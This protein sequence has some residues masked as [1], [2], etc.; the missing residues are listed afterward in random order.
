M[1]DRDI[2]PFF[3][4]GKKASF[5][6]R[7]GMWGS[8]MFN[9]DNIICG[10][11]LGSHRL[12]AVAGI[13]DKKENFFSLEHVGAK[14]DGIRS[15]LITD[16][17]LATR[18]LRE[19][20]GA[21]EGKLRRRIKS[22]YVNIDS[23]DLILR[24]ANA[25]IPLCERGN[26]IITAADIDLVRSQ[27][28]SLNLKLNEEKIHEFARRY[29]LDDHNKTENPKGLYGHK[30]AIDLYLAAAK[31]SQIENIVKLVNQAGL[32][33]ERVVFSG[34]AASLALLDKGL[35]ES[36]CVLVDIGADLT[37]VLVF[38]GGALC[39][40]EVMRYG[41]NNITASLAEVLK[42]PFGLAE[43]VKDTHGAA[44]SKDIKE[45][46]DVM[47]KKDDIYRSIRRRSITGII[48]PEVT[49][50]L[51]RL[52]EKIDTVTCLKGV[53][54]PVIISGG[55]GLLDGLLELAESIFSVSVK[56]G[57]PKAQISAESGAPAYGKS[58][59]SFSNRSVIYA[60]AIGLVIYGFEAKRE[61]R[62]RMFE[63]KENNI[64]TYVSTKAK[65]LYSEY[66]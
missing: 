60:T 50:L 61:S 31:L 5:R 8:S 18:V 29:T 20:M 26:K 33:A 53:D 57:I 15:G 45:D 41:G 12:K 25:V 1:A 51:T 43:E 35:K 56:L 19:A 13:L 44:T 48:E 47:V 17:S 59:F 7:R 42:L 24:R 39:F 9:Q 28:C 16:I 6:R 21:L 2:A 52:K 58:L 36:G 66:F 14:N 64:F 65:D 23:E 40:A 22:V 27:A 38:K 30:L 49:Q 63:S 62:L 3:G 55:T 46:E 34:F 32:E 4:A 11:D 54:Y 10:V 37:Q